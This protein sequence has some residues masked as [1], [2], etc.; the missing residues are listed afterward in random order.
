MRT[1]RALAGAVA[2]GLAVIVLAWFM[3]V[4][5]PAGSKIADVREQTETAQAEEQG[6]QATLAQLESI[7]E[8]R[9]EGEAE[10]RRLTAAVPPQPE[11]AAFILAV[12]DAAGRAD[13][14][15]LAITPS[16]PTEQAG[17]AASTIATTVNVEGSFFNVLEFLN[18]LE[19]M[20]RIV[21]VDAVNLTSA[22]PDELAGGEEEAAAPAP[23][24]GAAASNPA[25][26]V[27]VT[28][29]EGAQQISVTTDAATANQVAPTTTTTT[30]P[31]ANFFLV[32]SE[33]VPDIP[34][35]VLQMSLQ[36]RIFTT[37]PV[38]GAEGGGTTTPTTAPPADGATTTT[39]AEGA[40][41]TTA[42]AGGG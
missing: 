16:L 37:Q 7:D 29:G 20:E 8:D 41:T 32:P 3:F 19:E 2:G 22:G 36:I 4:Y 33:R 1:P 31:R 13:L 6:L 10:V 21:V 14:D 35:A 11:L 15:F 39:A 23:G 38:A 25:A 5:R 27:Q 42:P 26:P 12:H 30:S 34:N 40:T 9:P 18:R 17:V 24:A 28:F